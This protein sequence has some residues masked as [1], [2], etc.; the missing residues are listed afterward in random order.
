MCNAITRLFIGGNSST[1]SAAPPKPTQSVAPPPVARGT[2]NPLQDTYLRNFQ[3]AMRNSAIG[4]LG[5][6]IGLNKS[7]GGSGLNTRL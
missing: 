1:G 6:R 5:L 4:N 3:E 7:V 2:G